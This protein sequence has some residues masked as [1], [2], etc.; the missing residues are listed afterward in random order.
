MQTEACP[1]C[2][3]LE[4]SRKIQDLTQDLRKTMRKLR[5][6]LNFCQACT[7]Y[8]NCPVLQLFNSAVQAAIQEVND[9]WNQI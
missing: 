9:E 8:R 7:S 3:I 6:D 1:A 2:P 4:N 5:R